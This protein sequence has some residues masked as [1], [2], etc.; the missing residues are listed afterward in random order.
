MGFHL[1]VMRK[2]AAEALTMGIP[3]PMVSHDGK[4]RVTA[5]HSQRPSAE[6]ESEAIARAKASLQA[7]ES[8]GE[9]VSASIEAAAANTLLKISTPRDATFGARL[10]APPLVKQENDME[11]DASAPTAPA[12]APPRPTKA[13]KMPR[14]SA[15]PS[16]PA[17]VPESP[18]STTSSLSPVPQILSPND[19]SDGD[20]EDDDDDDMD[21]D[22]DDYV[23][24]GTRRRVAHRYNKR[25]IAVT[26]KTKAAA[27]TKRK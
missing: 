8:A 19:D 10:Y 13:G 3:I 7:L 9:Y 23:P 27:K 21:D 22:G 1:V 15:P 25:A 2:H 5:T 20:D 14:S 18:A 17:L 11:V 6:V 4:H 24:P 26:T 16:T 12:L